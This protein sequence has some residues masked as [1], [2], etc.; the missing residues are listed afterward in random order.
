MHLKLR[1][2]DDDDELLDNNDDDKFVITVPIT[3]SN[4]Y[5]VTN[6]FLTSVCAVD[7]VPKMFAKLMM[8][9]I[10]IIIITVRIDIHE[11]VLLHLHLPHTAG[12]VSEILPHPFQ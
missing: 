11:I 2:N 10:I 7:V 12:T 4:I 6:I 1:K 3:L 9:I 8:I 5:N